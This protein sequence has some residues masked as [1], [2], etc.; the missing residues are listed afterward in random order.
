MAKAK[1]PRCWWCGRLWNV[2]RLGNELDCEIDHIIP[3][4]RGGRDD[5]ANLVPTCRR[6]NRFK[7]GEELE[8]FRSMISHTLD[9]AGSEVEDYSARYLIYVRTRKFLFHCELALNK[10]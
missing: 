9:P 6:C 3:R 10:A 7:L 5:L 1:S 4:S 8:T 2:V